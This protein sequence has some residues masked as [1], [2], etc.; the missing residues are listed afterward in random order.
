GALDGTP[1]APGLLASAGAPIAAAPPAAA[2]QAASAATMPGLTAGAG[3]LPTTT[4]TTTTTTPA[5]S[6]S[7]GG[8]PA[9]M[10]S[11]ML[12]G[13][14]ASAA[15]SKTAAAAASAAIP[16]AKTTAAAASPAIPQIQPFAPA[17]A[18]A[19]ATQADEAVAQ[20]PASSVGKL[21]SA[22]DAASGGALALIMHEDSWVEIR[23]PDRSAIVSRMFKAG[24]AETFALD[25]PVLLIVGNAHG[26]DATLRGAPVEL[27]AGNNNIA[28]LNLK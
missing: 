9:L 13:N 12:N 23:R 4:T 26:V 15:P 19:L 14:P 18:Q 1:A 24:S 5:P 11:P 25:G 21:S 8:A 16:A 6:A 7:Q 2:G 17:P 22:L 27:R 20:S 3:N 28:R 10:A